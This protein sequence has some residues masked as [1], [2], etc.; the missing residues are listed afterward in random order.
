MV[1][2]FIPG[3]ACH[4]LH[5][6]Y[7]RHIPLVVLCYAANGP[8]DA[9]Q[10][11]RSAVIGECCGKWDP[12]VYGDGQRSI[13]QPSLTA[14]QF[15]LECEWWRNDQQQWPVYC[16]QHSRGSVHGYGFQR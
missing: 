5:I 9:D 10:H 6:A 1:Q 3:F 14:T 2:L 16:R 11:Q 7:E 4:L 15:H 8:F 13:G 12:A